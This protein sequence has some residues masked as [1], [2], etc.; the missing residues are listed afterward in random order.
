MLFRT[1]R[2]SDL[3]AIHKLAKSSGCG[4]TTLSKQLDVLERKIALTL[5]AINKK[6]H[7]PHDEYYLF[8]LEDPRTQQ[9]VGTSAIQAS[10]AHGA[11][12]YSYN[13][14]NQTHVSHPLGIYHDST[15]LILSSE[16]KKSSELC[17]LFLRPEY[18]HSHHG[19]FLSRARFLFMAEYP[20]RFE[21]VVI[22]EMRGVSDTRGN[23]PFWNS[24]GHHFIPMSFQEADAL[25]VSSNK[26]FIADL[27][28]VHPIPIVLLDKKAQ[29]VIGLP[30]PATEPAMRI[31][32]NEGFRYL[33][34]IDIFDAG[35]IIEVNFN[36]IHSIYSSKSATLIDT[37][38]MLDSSNYL[39]SNTQLNFKATVGAL[40]FSEDGVITSKK[41]ADLLHLQPG[42]H[43][44]F[45]SL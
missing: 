31:L 30:H 38:D 4:I 44:R 11:P 26:Q 34:S 16:L 27:F 5:D 29:D 32:I 14:V 21:S 24:L 23:S 33:H 41:T 3:D 42:D 9:V 40:S 43:L 6:T 20:A 12:F 37:I 2:S 19:G 36:E 15:W 35:P 8:V 1:V 45:V 22:A 13:L 7:H 10:L 39:I 28:P 18:R 17:T 25:T